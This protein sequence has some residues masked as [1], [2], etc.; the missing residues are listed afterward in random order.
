MARFLRFAHRML[1]EEEGATLIEY[2]L[3]IGV[4]AMA[5]VASVAIVGGFV[6]GAF[7]KLKL[8]IVFKL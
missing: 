6:H 1:M 8:S 7:E 3:L 2:S 5:V 4:L